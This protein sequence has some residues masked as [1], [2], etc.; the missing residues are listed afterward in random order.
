V[1][2]YFTMTTSPEVVK[3]GVH[4]DQ[5]LLKGAMECEQTVLAGMSAN[6]VTVMTKI[7]SRDSTSVV[8]CGASAD[9]VSNHNRG[10]TS[11]GRADESDL[12]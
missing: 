1:R 6:V 5:V 7:A 2:E 9:A 4:F 11:I 8:G 12:M 10:G 3:F